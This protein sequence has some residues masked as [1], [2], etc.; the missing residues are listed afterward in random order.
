MSA[1][2]DALT[3][4][5]TTLIDSRNGYEEALKDA[6]ED[7]MM[8]LFQEMVALRTA[9]AVEL[10]PLVRAAGGELKQDGSFMSTVHRAVISFQS[11]LTGLDE[12]ILPG[13]IDGEKRVLSSYDDAIKAASGEALGV[14]QRQRQELLQ[15]IAEMERRRVTAA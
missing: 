13:L 5:H 14:L 4:L 7:G 11:I 9:A 15:R 2:A 12:T 10:E 1:Y 8:T 3:S 6:S